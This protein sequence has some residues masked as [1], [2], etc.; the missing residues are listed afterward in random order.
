[1]N[2]ASMKPSGRSLA[3]L[4]VVLVVGIAAALMFTS[5]G[6]RPGSEPPTESPVSDDPAASE[7]HSVAGNATGS[8]E[9]G[10][11]P[12]RLVVADDPTRGRDR[13]REQGLRGRV[14]GAGGTPLEG[15]VVE[16]REG[17]GDSLLTAALRHQ[18]NVVVPPVDAVETGRDGRFEVGVR[19]VLAPDY[20]LRIRHHQFAER[21]V[22]GLKLESAVWS[23]LGDLALE[24]GV[25]LQGRVTVEGRPGFPIPDAVVTVL[26]SRATTALNP[27]AAD[28]SGLET[29]TDAAGGYR[30]PNVPAG[31]VTVRAVAAG[32]ALAERQAV[33][34]DPAGTNRVD[35][36]LSKGESIAGRIVDLRGQGIARAEV[37]ALSMSSR[38]PI[39]V[40]ARSATDG[41][42]EILG[43]RAGPYQIQVAA[44]GFVAE[45]RQPIAA[46]TD[47]LLFELG[48]RAAVPLRVLD[49][50]GQ[51]LP[52][53]DVVLKRY[54]PADESYGNVPDAR[55]ERVRERDLDE[56]GVFH[57]RG[58]DPGVYAF[59]LLAAEHAKTFTEPFEVAERAM[60]APV[61]ARML[62]GAHL[63]GRV[64]SADGLPLAGVRV[65]STPAELADNAF[66]AQ[67]ADL[68]TFRATR[69]ETRTDAEGR[70]RLNHLAPAE[71]RL[72]L[73]HQEHTS[74][75]VAGISLAEGEDR[76]LDDLRLD[77]GTR[78]SGSVL[79]N[80][81]P[82][83]QVKVSVTSFPDP[84]DP[85]RT[86]ILASA[87]TDDRGR[88]VLAERLPP[89][90]YTARA[91]RLTL[92]APLLQVLD[93][94]RTQT[95]FDVQ[96]GQREHEVHIEIQDA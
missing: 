93:Q 81:S 77:R 66:T 1:M 16:L 20:E 6:D 85:T 67:F 74:A 40:A 71:Y 72:S 49:A 24:P 39:R 82:A 79:V 3:L 31:I 21:R 80:G 29:R 73:S 47:D 28:D 26:P 42:F 84:K 38:N 90:R 23:E 63:G 45:R 44:D 76:T 8:T 5:G 14:V 59:Q 25:A 30:I 54:H 64:F 7:G 94:Q 96:T 34:I 56:N 12:E 95:D 15:A 46:G 91:A 58:V 51:P 36:E 22:G 11:P 4:L 86:P 70:F 55:L 9:Q 89:G 18:R 48:E 68:M 92:E 35:L 65:A 33:Q 32:F 43:L 52:L 83:A 50:D 27:D 69:A 87:V 17:P 57:Y 88:F 61:E 2:L 13:P 10:S 19:D 53:F 41:R 78:L 37:E 75:T 62:R 60:P